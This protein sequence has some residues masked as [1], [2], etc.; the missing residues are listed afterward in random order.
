[1]RPRSPHVFVLNETDPF[2]KH[3]TSCSEPVRDFKNLI[4][5]LG[6]K[7]LSSRNPNA[8]VLPV[9]F[10]DVVTPQHHVTLI[11]TIK[12]QNHF[13]I[14]FQ[15]LTVTKLA[16]FACPARARRSPLTAANMQQTPQIQ[17]K[18]RLCDISEP[19]MSLY[20]MF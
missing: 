4:Y 11:T 17:L 16:V 18:T 1:M 9:C 20:I 8:T 6:E 10:T 3:R 14:I 19:E 12:P 15:L 13:C 2:L 7:K 5:A